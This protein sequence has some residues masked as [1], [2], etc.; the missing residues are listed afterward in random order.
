MND[1]ILNAVINDILNEQRETNR[2]LRQMIDE[3]RALQEKVNGF[4][5]RLADQKIEAP[6]ADTTAIQQ[7]TTDGMEKIAALL[8]ADREKI[9]TIISEKFEKFIAI[10]EAQPK[11]IVRQLRFVF[12]PEHDHNGMYRFFLNRILGSFIILAIIAALFTLGRDYLNRPSDPF[13]SSNTNSPPSMQSHTSELP[14]TK[15]G[16]GQ[17]HHPRQQ[18]HPKPLPDSLDPAAV[19]INSDTLH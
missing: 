16:S 17:P 14:R 12:F 2:Q 18:K 10:V 19:T 7:V 1:E 3:H 6:P 13:S 5:Q 11:P 9:N 4:D 15:S 8:A